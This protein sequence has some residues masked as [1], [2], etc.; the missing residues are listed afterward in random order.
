MNMA[1]TYH[2]SITKLSVKID[3]HR[4]RERIMPQLFRNGFDGYAKPDAFR[5]KGMPKIM[6]MPVQSGFF[7]DPFE[8]VFYRRLGQISPKGSSA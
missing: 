6:E 3:I 4:E 1:P 2:F 8:S 7:A 5:G